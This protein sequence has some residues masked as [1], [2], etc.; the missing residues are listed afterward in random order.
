MKNK[1]LMSLPKKK[2]INKP[3]KKI[4]EFLQK[5]NR[6]GIPL[7][8]MYSKAY[9]NGILLSELLTTKEILDTLEIIKI[10]K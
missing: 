10:R 1:K 5:H 8:V 6:F 2:N 3:N 9:P 4:E 7:N